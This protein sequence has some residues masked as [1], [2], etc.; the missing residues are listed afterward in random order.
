MPNTKQ[1]LDGHSKGILSKSMKP[2]TTGTT[3]NCR[4]ANACHVPYRKNAQLNPLYIKPQSHPPALIPAKHTLDLL[5]TLLKLDTLYHKASFKN[6]DKKNATELR[7]KGKTRKRKNGNGKA[8]AEK[9]KKSKRRK[10]GK[11]GKRRKKG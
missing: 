8:E 3:C 5:K 9:R 1:T 7:G 11:K 10:S 2:K 6:Y 4:K